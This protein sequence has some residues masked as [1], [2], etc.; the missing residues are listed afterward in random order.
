METVFRL[1]VPPA[2]RIGTQQ[3]I[4]SVARVLL[5]PAQRREARE[6]AV[7]PRIASSFQAAFGTLSQ[8]RFV[9]LLR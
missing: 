7:T 6:R 5:S 9:C 1:N 3:S 2:G 8:G 4:H